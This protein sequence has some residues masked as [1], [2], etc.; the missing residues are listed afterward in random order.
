MATL[1]KG[2]TYT[3]G[4]TVT[5]GNLNALVDSA[6]I[7]GIV[8]ADI[9]AGAAI[10]P[11]KLAQ[12]TTASKV[13]G[14]SLTGLA[15]VV[16][17]AGVLPSA[18]SMLGSIKIGT[19]TRDMTAGTGDVAYTGVGFTPQLL[20]LTGGIAGTPSCAFNGFDNITAKGCTFQNDAG[21]QGT[22]STVV[23]KIFGAVAS[24]AYQ[25]AIVK[26]FDAD[27]FTLTWTKNNSPTGTATFVYVAVR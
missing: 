20:I 23:T 25:Q 22:L 15:S 27:G 5:H 14:S 4:M 2:T 1:S 8:N 24:D 12:I 21:N 26:T 10:A 11:T 6:T 17:G 7:S 19:F 3:D 9:D 13:H 16:S 18:N